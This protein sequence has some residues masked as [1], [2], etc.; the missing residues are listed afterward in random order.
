MASSVRVIIEHFTHSRGKVRRRFICIR[1]FHRTRRRVVREGLEHSTFNVALPNRFRCDGRCLGLE[2]DRGR[3]GCQIRG[4]QRAEATVVGRGFT[5]TRR[6][7]R[8]SVGADKKE[9][10]PVDVVLP[11]WQDHLRFGFACEGG[12]ANEENGRD[13]QSP[14]SDEFITAHMTLPGMAVYA[15]V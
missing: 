8:R 10:N 1:P 12:L 3:V 5:R 7:G 14:V 9:Y 4:S 15:D 13:P 2:S 6:G 11:G